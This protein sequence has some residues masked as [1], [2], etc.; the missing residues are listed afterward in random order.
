M[1]IHIFQDPV[2]GVLLLAYTPRQPSIGT[3]NMLRCAY[4]AGL[5]G[6]A[7]INSEDGWSFVPRTSHHHDCNDA[8]VEST[9]DR[10]RGRAANQRNRNTTQHRVSFSHAGTPPKLA[11]GNV[12]QVDTSKGCAP[13]LLYLRLSREDL[14]LCTM[15]T[16]SD[17]NGLSGS[18]ALPPSSARGPVALSESV[19]LSAWE[20]V[21]PCLRYRKCGVG[22]DGVRD[23]ASGPA[24]VLACGREGGGAGDD[25][26]VTG[27]YL[28]GHPSVEFNTGI[29]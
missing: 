20:S 6:K 18:K 3:E 5:R 21:F 11:P 27:E 16:S 4:R 26:A 22:G 10:E 14:G 28:W 13:V 12:L 29:V 8:D 24:K 9:H 23:V 19:W 7:L 1:L 2:D 25:D 17:S 15:S